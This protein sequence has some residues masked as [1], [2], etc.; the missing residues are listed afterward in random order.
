LA[1][2][3]LQELINETMAVVSSGAPAS[4]VLARLT[5]QLA[6]IGAA[7]NFQGK[8][9]AEFTGLREEFALVAEQ[10]MSVADRARIAQQAIEM[11]GREAQAAATGAV[12]AMNNTVLAEERVASAARGAQ[13]S[14][15]GVT[16]FLTNLSMGSTMLAGG[17]ITSLMG[18]QQ[19]GQA[20]QE[21]TNGGVAFM[22]MAA[23]LVPVIGA[24]AAAAIV[25]KE[26]FDLL[27]SGMEGAAQDELFEIRM[28]SVMGTTK[29]TKEALDTIQD[30]GT[31]G[32]ES[33]I[34]IDSLK[35]GSI[36]LEQFTNGALS[37]GEG[38]KIVAGAAAES[39]KSFE[40]VA[41]QIGRAY[42]AI[43]TGAPIR[44]GLLNSLVAESV[45]SQNDAVQIRNMAKEHVDAQVVTQKFMDSL[46]ESSVAADQAKNSYIGLVTQL[47]NIVA[48]D[49]AEP[50][51]GAL[52][53]AFKIPLAT[54]SAFLAGQKGNIET[55]ANEIEVQLLYAFLTIRDKGIG[56]AWQE[57]VEA[58]GKYISD[59]WVSMLENIGTTAFEHW[60]TSSLT[61]L[62]WFDTQL[63]GILDP[64]WNKIT[65]AST[66]KDLTST[67]SADVLT[68]AQLKVQQ[69][70]ESGLGKGDEAFD[71]AVANLQKAEAENAA[72]AQKQSDAA[73]KQTDS[74]T[75]QQNAANIALQAAKMTQEAIMGW[76]KYLQGVNQGGLS[77][78]GAPYTGPVPEGGFTGRATAFGY[79]GDTS[80]DTNSPLGIGAYDQ[81]MVPGSA[82]SMSQLTGA[83]LGMQHMQQAIEVLTDRFGN[84][85]TKLVYW[86]DTMDDASK[87]IIG[88][89]GVIDQF[90]PGLSAEQ[91][92]TYSGTTRLIP[93]PSFGRP[94]EQLTPDIH[95]AGYS[96]DQLDQ[97]RR[98]TEAQRLAGP[99]TVPDTKP[100]TGLG[101]L[102]ELDQAVKKNTD[103]LKEYDRLVNQIRTDQSVYGTTMRTVQEQVRDGQI[104]ISQGKSQEIKLTN[105][106]I[107]TLNNQIRALQQVH[108]AAVLA[109]DTSLISKSENEL[110]KLHASLLK[111]EADLAKLGGGD[112]WKSFTAG[113]QQAINSWGD[114]SQQ[115]QGAGKDMTEA[116]SSG[117]V[118]GLMEL[119]DGT[120]TAKEAF[121]DM[122]KSILQSIEQIILKLLVEQAIEAASKVLGGLSGGGEVFSGGGTV[123]AAMSG[124]GNVVAAKAE[125]GPIG[126]DVGGTVGGVSGV[127]AGGTP[128]KDSVHALLTPG[129][130]VLTTDEYANIQK[131]FGAMSQSGM[132]TTH[133]FAEGGEVPG[134]AEPAEFAG[135]GSVVYNTYAA[136]GHVDASLGQLS[137]AQRS[138][139]EGHSFN[140]TVNVSGGE[141]S[142][143]SPKEARQFQEAITQS[144]RYEISKQR[145]PGGLLNRNSGGG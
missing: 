73:Q 48:E 75:G 77:G 43:A 64:I 28:K 40:E 100:K 62:N 20:F 23:G 90:L 119:T 111:Y 19:L 133:G 83:D 51:G 105:D 109:N 50:I 87:G 59:N 4:E 79:K 17:G 2:Q 138:A 18:V 93:L 6:Q 1:A 60:K 71:A 96:Q 69:L 95:S 13:A 88:K 108:S 117:V 44:Q 72:S 57:G 39:G 38:L 102:D 66:A 128:G 56:G 82:V 7:A 11:F 84:V 106:E 143:M 115:V 145:K 134:A 32:A 107:A 65:Q 22:A 135:G 31:T 30:A 144:I 123:G 140:T 67:V 126:F 12:T 63:H 103:G 45:I 78:E 136:G 24:V 112:V 15:G 139:G 49:I 94:G 85:T 27:R 124:F 5:E 26:A 101:D 61:F 91:G 46:K 125:G 16:S 10:E 42:G 53:E 34:P 110:E 142:G 9:Q 86:A 141:G 114:L 54:F 81:R 55:L 33:F 80:F 36:I 58:V 3:A 130:F 116:I 122:A 35:A 127:V 120:H 137:G 21:G 97:Q 41:T 70:T 37:T 8:L 29:A 76:A 121:A 52:N 104:S 92:N 14:L 68:N 98:M 89:R 118:N 47:Q 74:A 132:G 113:I 25:A 99:Q 131:L 129:E